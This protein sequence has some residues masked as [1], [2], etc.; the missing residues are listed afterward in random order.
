MP[1]KDPPVYLDYDQTGLKGRRP[2]SALRRDRR[3]RGCRR[4]HGL[5][6]RRSGPH[7]SDAGRRTG[8]KLRGR[9]DPSRV[10]GSIKG[11]TT[12]LTARTG[13]SNPVPSSTESGVNS[14]FGGPRVKA[15]GHPG[16]TLDRENALITGTIL[17]VD[18]G[19]PLGQR[20]HLVDCLNRDRLFARRSGLVAQQTRQPGLRRTAAANATLPDGSHRPATCSTGNRSAESRTMRARCTCFTG[21]VRSPTIAS[22]RTRSS[23]LTTAQS[24]WAIRLRYHIQR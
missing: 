8:R 5:R 1:E 11:V 6:P 20:Q 19:L 2:H 10:F 13:S 7:R 3:P 15:R 16:M 18:G 21:R 4:R 14:L 9:T 22:K 17:T 24:S 23:P 12:R